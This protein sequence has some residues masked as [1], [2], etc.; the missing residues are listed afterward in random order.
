MQLY[1]RKEQFVP[2][3][4]LSCMLRRILRVLNKMTL[5]NFYKIVD[6]KQD[7]NNLW[8]LYLHILNINVFT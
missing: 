6:N 4:S 7:S 1:T 2:F 3:H 5:L 8:S